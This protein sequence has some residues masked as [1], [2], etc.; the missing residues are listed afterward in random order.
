VCIWGLLWQGLQYRRS[1]SLCAK[2]GGKRSAHG[3]SLGPA[4]DQCHD[5]PACCSYH[6]CL[7]L[8]AITDSLGC[9]LPCTCPTVQQPLLRCSYCTDINKRDALCCGLFL[10]PVQVS[11]QCQNAYSAGLPTRPSWK[12]S[13]APMP[14]PPFLS[15]RIWGSR[16]KYWTAHPPATEPMGAHDQQL[17][18]SAAP[19]RRSL[20]HGTIFG[21]LGVFSVPR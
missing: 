14:L 20:P 12:D 10:W 11:I 16:G 3:M 8:S 17:S 21:G 7:Q 15:A 18:Q 5:L 2:C 19:L 13:H 9:T 1:D 6:N 4:H